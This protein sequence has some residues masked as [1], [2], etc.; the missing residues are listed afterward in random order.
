MCVTREHPDTALEVCETVV[1][2]WAEVYIAQ[3]LV[4]EGVEVYITPKTR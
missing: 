3:T 2:D 1:G 4:G